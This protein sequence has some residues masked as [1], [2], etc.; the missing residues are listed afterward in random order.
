MNRERVEEAIFN[1]YWGLWYY[2]LLL[3]YLIRVRQIRSNFKS[4]LITSVMQKC[5]NPLTCSILE[6]VGVTWDQLCDPFEDNDFVTKGIQ[7]CLSPK[8]GWKRRSEELGSEEA[9]E[10]RQDACGEGI[11][12]GIRVYLEAGSTPEIIL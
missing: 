7:N 12:R 1:F 8:A 11:L 5:R 9:R 4:E 6:S 3:P 2:F 10:R